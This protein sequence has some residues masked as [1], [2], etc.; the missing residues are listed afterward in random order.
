MPNEP[1]ETPV[2]APE[3]DWPKEIAV[4][5][6]RCNSCK[7]VF[8]IHGETEKEDCSF[9]YATNRGHEVI[10]TRRYVPETETTNEA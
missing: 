8:F 9:C 5:A 10:A 2:A 6:L 4:T 7:R 1:A 3:T